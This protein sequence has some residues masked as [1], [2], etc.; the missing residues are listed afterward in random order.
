MRTFN[1]KR[2][3]DSIAVHGEKK[4]SQLFCKPYAVSTFCMSR[5]DSTGRKGAENWNVRQKK[6][7]LYHKKELY[8]QL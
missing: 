8:I 4:M 5:L 2:I 3:S 6:V 7:E 1:L